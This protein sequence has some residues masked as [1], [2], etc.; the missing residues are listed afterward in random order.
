[1]VSSDITLLESVL[2]YAFKQPRLLRQALTHRSYGQPHNERLEFLGDSVLNTVAAR[3]L[4]DAFPL[5]SEGELSRL[6]ASLVKQETLAGLAHQLSL[7]DYLWLGEGEARSGGQQRP[8]ILADALEAVFAAIYLDSTFE[9]ASF[10]VAR[11]LQPL[12]TSLDPDTHGKDSKTQLQEWLQSKR[13]PLPVYRIVAQDAQANGQQFTIAC[14]IES[15]KIVTEG[16]GASRRIA[17]QEA[18]GAA[19]RRLL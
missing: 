6:R 5:R 16:S 8:S 10:S 2:G 18:A 17:E 9:Q 12:I 7:G 3:L 1:M 13:F 14:E 19:L 11:L 4:F 15:L